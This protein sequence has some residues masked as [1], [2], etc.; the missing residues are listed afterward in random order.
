M[1]AAV[2]KA[3]KTGEPYQLE[4]ALIRPGGNIRNVNAF[5]G[6]KYDAK[7]QVTGLYGT[8]QDIT[9]RKQAE[10]ALRESEENLRSLVS[11][12]PDYISLLDREGRFLLLN[13]FAEGFKEKEVLGSS[14]YQYFSTQS[15]EIFEKEVAECQN[16][17]K[18]R[19]FEHTAMG[20][21]G[22]MRE[23]E[24]YLVPFLEK[25]KATS[26]LVISRDIT[27]RKRAEE[28]LRRAEEN[29]RRTLDDSPLGARIVT[30][31][32]E[33]IYANRAILGI[34][35]YDSIEELRTTPVKNS[36]TPESYATF[37]IRYDK[38]QKGEEAPSE[39]EI[40]IV[41][42]NGEVRSLQVFRKEVLWNDE[43]QYQVLY[44]DITERKRAEEALRE[45]GE[46]FRALVENAFE[47]TAI[48]SK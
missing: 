30:T 41:K 15:K 26:T 5:G 21:Y 45:S 1:K 12:L 4:L 46:R 10:E 43:K 17:G 40:S 3:L 13:H 34:Y 11:V 29:F 14:V 37:Q 19:K 8:L 38:R 39:Y 20:D 16:T 2:E 23:Y 35:G 44:L 42:K 22:I 27:K 9:E 18:I 36:Y 31:E 6:V 48:I 47:G 28:A 33:T 24:D 32:G 25:N 7:G